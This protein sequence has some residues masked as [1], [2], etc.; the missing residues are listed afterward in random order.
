MKRDGASAPWASFTALI[1]VTALTL[2]LTSTVAFAQY[3]PR[4]IPT[5][6]TNPVNPGSQRYDQMAPIIIA[7]APSPYPTMSETMVFGP[8]GQITVIQQ[9]GT[10]VFIRTSP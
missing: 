8:N 5:N 3:R 2:I 1:L 6:P 10:D 7:P 9:Q 4:Q